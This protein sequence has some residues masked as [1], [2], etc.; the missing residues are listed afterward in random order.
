MAKMVRKTLADIKV[1]PAMERRLKKL[2]ERP[3][4]E[5]DLSD[6][7]ELTED[8]FKNAVR[9]PF[10][11][12]LKEQVTVRLDSDILAWLKKKGAGYQTRMNALLRSAMLAETASKPR[13]R[14][15]R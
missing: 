14:H 8:F 12:P 10:Y 7:P 13:T 3:D 5:I 6:I 11:R 15:A 9:N 2:A 1:T 4:S